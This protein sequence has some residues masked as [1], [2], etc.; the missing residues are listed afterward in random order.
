M[1]V[2]KTVCCYSLAQKKKRAEC[3][4]NPIIASRNNDQEKTSEKRENFQPKLIEGSFRKSDKIFF[5]DGS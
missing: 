5:W 3:Q 1:E 4:K 2:Y